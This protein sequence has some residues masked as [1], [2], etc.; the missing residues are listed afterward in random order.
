MKPDDQ[1]P[2]PD[3]DHDTKEDWLELHRANVR[4]TRAIAMLEAALLVELP[5]LSYRSMPTL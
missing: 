5:K 3:G 1:I 2:F 4:T